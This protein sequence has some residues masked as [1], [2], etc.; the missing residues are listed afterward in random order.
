MAILDWLREF[1]IF[2]VM[3]R[4]FFAFILAGIVGFERQKKGHA[5]GLRTHILVCIGATLTTLTGIYISEILK[6]SSDPMRIGAQVVSGIGF[7]GAGTILVTRGTHVRGLTTA[8][9]LWATA[10]IGL[11][12]G[13]GFYEGAILSTLLIAVVISTM[14]SLDRVLNRKSKY[15][16]VYIEI[17]GS[18]NVNA[19]LDSLAA[20]NVDISD[21][22][23]TP[24]RSNVSG[25]VGISLFM[26][27]KSKTALDE[28]KI[29][30]Y[31][32]AIDNVDIVLVCE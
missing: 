20:L 21:T 31:I 22:D 4:L 29:L 24:A 5:A 23:I 6:Y 26:S 12:L 8:A 16:E 17:K 28:K 1:N 7:I 14:K 10:A 2:T 15:I 25:N 9:G 13:A 3:I 11:C 19:V 18:E 27:A 30:E 32:R